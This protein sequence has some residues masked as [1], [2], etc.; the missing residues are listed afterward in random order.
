M[1]S[2]RAG[3]IL[4]HI[5]ELILTQATRNLSDGQLLQ[6]FVTAQEEAA[7]SALM[8]RHSTLVW[9]VC[10][11][12]LPREHDAEDAFQATFLVLARKAGSIRKGESVGSWLF[13]VAHRVAMKAKLAASKRRIRESHSPGR[14]SEEPVT[15]AAL[16][17]LQARLDTE[18]DRLP[19]KYKAPFVLCC[20]EGKSRAEAAAELGWKLGTVA[21]G[22]ARARNLLRRRLARRGV[23][24]SAGLAAL[25]LTTSAARAGCPAWLASATLKAALLVAAGKSAAG[26]VS[27]QAAVLARTS[28]QT[29]FTTRLKIATVL[30]LL[31]G[32]GAGAV[33]HFALAAKQPG[34][35][36]AEA[37][38][39]SDKP[40]EQ[41][42]LDPSKKA[43]TDRRGDL[44]PPGALDRF[45]TGRLRHGAPVRSV[46]YSTDGKLLASAGADWLIR[47]WEPATG[48]QIRLLGSVTG[49]YLALALSRNG[50]LL[51]SASE[52]KIKRSIRLWDVATGK[53][54]GPLKEQRGTAVAV[55]FA[56][57]SKLLAAA[58]KE[59]DIPLYDVATCKEKR[60]LAG[61]K[62]GT[63]A[64]VFAADG[65]TLLSG[66]QD[67]CLR[68]WD[69]LTGKERRSFT[70]HTGPVHGVAF[71]S[72]GKT[73]ASGSD[74]R[75]A[76]VWDVQTG[77]ELHQLRGHD[78]GIHALAFA[79]GDKTL[80]TAGQ[81]GRFCLWQVAT[82]RQLWVYTGRRA[83]VHTVAFASDGKTFA[84]GS[85][86]YQVRL[87]N[88]ATGRE[89]PKEGGHR[90]AVHGLGFSPDG[91]LLASAGHD[92][93][94]CVW[95]MKTR[96]ERYRL[97][98]HASAVEAVAF[99]P[100][101]RILA[102]VGWDA[103]VC[104][105]DM[106]TGKERGQF[107]G[108]VG[109]LH[110]VAWSPDGKR[111]AA[112]GNNGV[113]PLWEE[114]TRQEIRR[115]VGHKGWITHL[116]FSPDGKFLVSAALDGTVRVWALQ[117]GD[118][119]YTLPG[120]ADYNNAIALAP[121]GRTLVSRTRDGTVHLWEL[122]TGKERARFPIK[123]RVQTM[124]FAPDGRHLA[125]YQGNLAISVRDLSTTR[126]AR[127][128]TGHPV[129]FMTMTFSPDGRT[130]AAGSADST[131]VLWDMAGIGVRSK[132]VPLTAARLEG[133]WN[134]LT[135]TDAAR[136]Y[137]A[138]WTLAASGDQAVSLVK[139][140]LQT[141]TPVDPKK[142]G[143]LIAELDDDDFSVREKAT[144]ELA[145][146]G[147]AAEAPLRKLLMEDLP[148]DVRVRAEG[149][150]KKLAGG[151]P[152]ADRW[153]KLRMLEV[154]EQARTAEARAL[155]KAASAGK[156]DP[157]LA[158]EAQAA[159][160]RMSRRG[161]QM[162]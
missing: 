135:G 162:R 9:G 139:R 158:Q 154:L 91:N 87:W 35:K 61:H 16:H 152:P 120:N 79:P 108:G 150:L 37:E 60:R 53:Q 52:D 104:L 112:G 38:K 124:A 43:R 34:V 28:L 32:L 4:R 98:G 134:A 137:R 75:T 127:C 72:D 6:H 85:Q 2:E 19:A 140:H 138:L 29:L 84:S 5:R 30:L 147:T 17:E 94:V 83:A 57:D 123:E 109:P 130:L 157:W 101:G 49:P 106:A 67:N 44:L 74:D 20:L 64:V 148:V 8:Q 15:G 118:V 151:P 149:V 133:E 41:P 117:T 129:W 48:K 88:V 69:P 26:V 107:Q 23:R 105:W 58:T 100:H 71:A 78:L 95:D 114:S 47:F 82:G 81:E 92:N 73:V 161:G 51:A 141:A 21:T 116:A 55:A 89:I 77:R 121:D 156:T 111:L 66:G 97:N 27:A 159:L 45:G 119:L 96:K 102:S 155:L 14:V 13:G 7:F 90:A 126:E 22:V 63:L 76:R 18:V 80:L 42:R 128:F 125:L 113:I 146:L 153:R 99:A 144:A 132:P 86:D 25:T 68:L 50:K 11:R 143:K 24:L 59:G 70:G 31:V 33:A 1:A 39:P 136:A 12:Y 103:R 110:C 65:K 54:I 62:G 160:Q 131:I 93:L 115:L 36:Q 122:A 40:A 142:I 145:R 46:A 10:R 3:T 56:P